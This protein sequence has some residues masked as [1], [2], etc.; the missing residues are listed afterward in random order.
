MLFF[1]DTMFR[2]QSESFKYSNYIVVEC[3]KIKGLFLNCLSN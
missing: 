1:M 3:F 2:L